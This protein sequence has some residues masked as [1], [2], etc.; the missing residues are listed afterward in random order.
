MTPF[1]VAEPSLM[2]RGAV[3]LTEWNCDG[4][5]LLYEPIK[6]PLSV[7]FKAS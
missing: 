2:G 5:G 7:A 1:A 4:V 6:S 3:G